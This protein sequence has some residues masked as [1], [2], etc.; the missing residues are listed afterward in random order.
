MADSS[1]LHTGIVP[2]SFTTHS[3]AGARAVGHDDYTK[4]VDVS[5]YDQQGRYAAALA[6]IGATHAPRDIK[7][8]TPIFQRDAAATQRQAVK[9]A[10]TALRVLWKQSASK[11]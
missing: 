8:Y 5:P 9:D 2:C 11:P 7:R 3:I 1:E 4:E 10:A 6:K